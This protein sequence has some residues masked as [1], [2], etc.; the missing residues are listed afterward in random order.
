MRFELVALS[1]VIVLL[2]LPLL[3]GACAVELVFLPGR[4]AAGEWWRVLTHV[5]VHVSWYHLLLDATA[6]LLLYQELREKQWFAR[7]GCVL[8]CGAGCLLVSLWAAPMIHTRGLCGLSGIAH[9][10]MVIAAL[11]MVRAGND[12]TIRRA[13]FISFALVVTKC[14]IE[15]ATGSILLERLHL[16]P[17]GS[18]VAV[19]HAGGVLGGLVGWVVARGLEISSMSR[20]IPRQVIHGWE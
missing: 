15:A 14:M 3:H 16:G 1:V 9:G 7:I 6:F 4:V 13:G 5:F 10:L 12:A 2:N 11:D 17:L 19:C 20:L 8:A 18:P